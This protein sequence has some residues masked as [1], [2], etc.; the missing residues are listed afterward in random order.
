MVLMPL[1]AHWMIQKQARLMAAELF[2]V[3]AMDNGLYRHLTNG[4]LLLNGKPVTT[5]KK[6]LAVFVELTAPKLYEDARQALTA[7]LALP[8]ET[9]P[10]LLKNAI[11]EALIMDNELRGNRLV[12]TEHAKVPRWLH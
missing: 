12:A 11:A 5:A 6:A 9:L 10:V 7:L 8:D 2:D 3:Y 4:T 1:N